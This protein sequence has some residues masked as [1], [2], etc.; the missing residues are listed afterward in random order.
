M[1]EVYRARDTRLGREVA[2]KTLPDA[3]ARDREHV[4]RFLREGRALA[5]LNHPNIGAIHGLEYS[6]GQ[7]YLVLEFVDGR[8]LADRLRRGPL[9]VAEAVRVCRQIAAGLEAAHEGGIVHRDLKPSNVMLTRT[10]VIKVLDFGLAKDL[11]AARDAAVSDA[12]ALSGTTEGTMLGTPAYMSPEQASGRAT[13]RR[14]DIWAFGCVLYEC[15]VGRPVFAGESYAEV[16]GQVLHAKPD[17]AALPAATP[18]RVRELV[19]RCLTRDPTQRLRD[20]GEARIALQD[21]APADVGGHR[22]VSRSA[23]GAAPLAP[24]AATASGGT[25][26]RRGVS[27]L[28]LAAIV[29]AVAVIAVAVGI[30]VSR[31]PWLA[32]PQPLTLVDLALP[33]TLALFGWGSPVLAFA[34]DGRTLA[35]SAIGP[36]GT[37]RIYVHQLTDG[38]VREVPGSE[39]GEGPFFSPDG[40]WV[41]FGVGVGGTSRIPSEL[42]KFS[43]STGLTQAMCAVQDYNGGF[44]EGDQIVWSDQLPGPLMRVPSAGGTPARWIATPNAPD[45]AT[46]QAWPQPLP[47]GPHILVVDWSQARPSL[48]VIDRRSGAQRRLWIEGI[49]ARYLGKGRLLC[50][51]R[52]GQA[53]VVPFDPKR[54]AVTG[55]PVAVLKDISLSG[56]EAAILAYSGAGHLAWSSG[57]VRHSGI[58]E[59]RLV[60]VDAA[61]RITPLPIAGDQY[62]RRVRVSPDGRRLVVS[63]DRGGPWLVDLDRGIRSRIFQEQGYEFPAWLPDGG[64]VVF[65]KYGAPF[66][67]MLVEARSGATPRRVAGVPGESY[68]DDVTPDGR[69]I[70]YT[71]AY[72]VDVRSVPLDGTGPGKVLLRGARA[73]NSALSPD[74]RWLAYRSSVGGQPEVFVERVGGGDRTQVSTA[75]GNSPRWARDGREL[76]F[77]SGARLMAA[78]F[79]AGGPP[80]VGVPVEVATVPD[81]R[82]YDVLPGH[83]QFVALQRPPEAGYVRR[84]RLALNWT[85][86]SERLLEGT[87]KLDR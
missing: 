28:T 59:L 53:R 54:A 19:E 32:R 55:A 57:L 18:D 24:G 68:P 41:A 37:A 52:E 85:P 39:T 43:L 82:G 58:E 2:I 71:G 65:V 60:R 67:F 44:W 1:G 5:S 81:I 75:G 23:A 16:V 51:T 47:G 30:A 4:T 25:Q 20:I 61:G 45:T 70:T 48:A 38:V 77:V 66:A 63:D 13:D 26:G 34:P 74:G 29:T 3:F 10:D 69:E 56:N 22:G 86:E 21:D 36:S 84:L 11:G 17:W 79:T 78:Q 83:R 27:P 12:A 46:M 73:S 64:A 40:A 31:L 15:L 42:R 72:S 50:V 80:E 62:G 35:Y 7:S 14:T 8:T 87:V 49:Y 33:D 6:G 76:Y 9:P